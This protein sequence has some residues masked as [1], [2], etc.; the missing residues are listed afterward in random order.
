MTTRGARARQRRWCVAFGALAITASLVA[1]GEPA[2]PPAPIRPVRAVI[3]DPDRTANT[4]SVAGEI[5]ARF[6]VPLGFR[7]SGKMI[8][9]NVDVGAVVKAGE[10]IAM[11]DDRDARNALDA[12]KSNLFAAQS[13]LTQLR[14]QEGR[15]RQLL[16]DGYVPQARYDESLRDLQTGEATLQSANASLQSAQDQLAYTI[17]TA[18][19]DGVITAVGADAGQVVG[20]GQMPSEREGLFHVAESWLRGPPRRISQLSNP[21]TDRS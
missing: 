15:M 7:V 19:R 6:E 18:P 10:S 1:C 5:K 2:P 21:V 12:A 16:R 14:S 13:A 4:Y 9:R 8:T 3:V 17:L 11:I 20:A